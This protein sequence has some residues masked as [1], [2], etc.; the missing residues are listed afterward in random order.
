MIPQLFA[1]RKAY[2]EN[3]IVSLAMYTLRHSRSHYPL[4][5]C[6]T[7]PWKILH[8][9]IPASFVLFQDHRALSGVNRTAVGTGVTKMHSL[10]YF[11]SSPSHIRRAA[12]LMHLSHVSF[13]LL[14]NLWPHFFITADG[15]PFISLKRKGGCSRRASFSFLILLWQ[16]QAGGGGK[17]G[18]EGTAEPHTTSLA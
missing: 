4:S 10:T 2:L 11:M 9:D 6:C 14:L 8:Q 12:I 15:L 1:L 3:S 17:G 5:F 7:I 13:P 18:S 16:R